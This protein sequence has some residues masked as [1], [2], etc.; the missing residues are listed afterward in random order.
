MNTYSLDLARDSTVCRFGVSKKAP[1][2]DV[3]SIFEFT[4]APAPT[5][6]QTKCIPQWLYCIV[7]LSKVLSQT[8][9]LQDS[10]KE[11]D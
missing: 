11:T 9:I 3:P 4:V 2:P 5:A 7:F 8:Y 10:T 1:T 6:V